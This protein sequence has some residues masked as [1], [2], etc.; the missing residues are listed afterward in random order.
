MNIEANQ[1]WSVNSKAWHNEY[2]R[3]VTLIGQH[4]QN[5][6]IWATVSND[7][8]LDWHGAEWLRDDCTLIRRADGSAVEPPEPEPPR[9]PQP[10]S[11][12]NVYRTV[13]GDLRVMVPGGI[14]VYQSRN[15]DQG[16]GSSGYTCKGFRFDEDPEHIYPNA[17]G[18]ADITGYRNDV[19]MIKHDRYTE[20]TTAKYAVWRRLGAKL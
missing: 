19:S 14:M 13:E 2:G 5:Y 15:A 1:V 10:D 6:A 11:L 9:E 17:Q 7:N 18:W 3:E 12:T 8:K 4:P 20:H 16:V